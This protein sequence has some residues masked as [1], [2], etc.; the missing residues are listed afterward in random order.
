[1]RGRDR[2]L[3]AGAPRRAASR[4]IHAAAGKVRRNAPGTGSRGVPMRNALPSVAAVSALLLAAALGAG[5]P[6][7]GTLASGPGPRAQ[8]GLPFDAALTAAV[9]D[10]FDGTRVQVELSRVD[11]VGAHPA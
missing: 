11:V 9:R 6:V 1:R 3:N 8:A 7:T 2:R 5:L 10:A 4:G